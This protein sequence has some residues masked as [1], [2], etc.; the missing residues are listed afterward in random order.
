KFVHVCV[1]MVKFYARTMK[2]RKQE[3]V[4]VGIIGEGVLGILLQTPDVLSINVA[5][6][7]NLKNRLM[8]M[9]IVPLVRDV[10]QSKLRVQNLLCLCLMTKVYLRLG[11]A[12][13]T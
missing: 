2:I 7:T 4:R 5:T 10:L 9:L 12:G 6:L 3:I 1:R 8:T 11:Y 13:S